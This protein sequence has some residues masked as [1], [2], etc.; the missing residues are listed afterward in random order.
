MTP[1]RLFACGTIVLS[2]LKRSPR[3]H[4]GLAMLLLSLFMSG[5]T[6][7]QSSTAWNEFRGPTQ[8]GISTSVKLPTE[9]GP[10]TNITWRK[11]LPGIG[12]SSPVTTEDRIYLTTAVPQD[13]GR[14]ADQSLRTVC[15]D[16]NSGDVVWN[17]EVF[18][19]SGETAPKIHSKNS[20]A[21]ATPIV[22]GAFVYVHFGHMGTACLRKQD[23]AIVWSTQEHA[24]KP[25]HGNGGSPVLFGDKLI[26]SIDGNDKQ[27]VIALDKETGQVAWRTP[28]NVPGL[29]KYFA[30][31]TPLLIEVNGQ[32]QLI[33]QGSGAV[34]S[35]DPRN[36]QEIWR[37]TYGDG[38]SVVPRPI[39][40]NGLI[41][42]CTGYDR[43]TLIAMRPDGHGDVTETHVEFILDR[44]VPYNPSP[45]VVDDDVYMISDNGIL[46]CVDGITGDVRWKHRIGGNFSAS[47]LTANGLIYM[48]DESGKATVV[49]HADQYEEVAQNDL[50]ERA[51]A[52]FGIHNDAILLRTEKALYRIENK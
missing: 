51:L 11:E 32:T 24:Y 38:Y 9:W 20:H 42:V 50:A 17:V 12:W 47:L 1:D 44:N 39:F 13:E 28:R 21:S 18:Q 49:R 41:Y 15:L 23:G 31:C 4:I 7:A 19:Q 46:S 3:A 40:A 30:F 43:S 16:A 25:T 8:Q 52:S 2:L 33:S 5:Q 26:F 36:G 22:E 35:L 27:A 34:M 14:K 45:V 48:L 37:V 10:E 29:P 6:V